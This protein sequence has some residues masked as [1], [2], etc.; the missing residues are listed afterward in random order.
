MPVTKNIIYQGALAP[1]AI[2]ITIGPGESAQD[3]S[4]VSSAEIEVYQDGE[5]VM[6]WVPVMSG[7][8][9]TSL[10]LTYEFE[11]GD[12][13]NVGSYTLLPKLSVPAG[14]VRCDPSNIYIQS[15][16]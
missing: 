2:T 1:E 5:V 12:T 11:A 16:G 14:T 9:S 4:D 15:I 7:Q 3:L 8:T 10:T 13:D 6:T